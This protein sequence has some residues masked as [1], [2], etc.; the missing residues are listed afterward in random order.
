VRKQDVMNLGLGRLDRQLTRTE[1]D[2][3]AGFVGR[4]RRFEVPPLER[5][6][7]HAYIAGAPTARQRTGDGLVLVGDAAGLA[8]DTSGEGIGPAVESGLMAANV[9][10]EGGLSPEA[11]SRYEGLVARRWPA[12]G[13]LSRLTG[14]VPD[15]V[16]RPIA[17]RLLRSPGFVRRV[18]LNRWFL[19]ANE[20]A[21]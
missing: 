17:R 18:V 10:L 13:A 19:H 21:A 9:I 11:L 15:A 7:G 3:F 1:V 5:W 2:A 16:A 4:R 20:I 12:P 6:R 14:L 8:S